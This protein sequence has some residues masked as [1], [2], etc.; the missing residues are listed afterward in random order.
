MSIAVLQLGDRDAVE[1][2]KGYVA[3]APRVEAY[4]V[5]GRVGWGDQ[6]VLFRVLPKLT[7]YTATVVGKNLLNTSDSP[8]QGRQRLILEICDCAVGSAGVF[9]LSLLGSFRS[10]GSMSTKELSTLKS[11]LAFQP[12][13]ADPSRSSEWLFPYRVATGVE[14]SLAENK[15]SFNFISK[16]AK[17]HPFGESRGSVRLI[18]IERGEPIAAAVVK[19]S[20]E[21]SLH[22]QGELRAFG[23]DYRA[24]KLTSLYIARLYS[25]KRGHI[26][27]RHFEWLLRAIIYMAPNVYAEPISYISGV[28]YDFIPAA[29]MTGF[30][31]DLPRQ[32]FGSIFYWK[33]VFANLTARTQSLPDLKHTY[34]LLRAQ[35]QGASWLTSA[36]PARLEI[37]IERGAWAVSDAN[38]NRGRW[39]SVRPGDVL[40]FCSAQR[41]VLGA[42]RIE[43][44][45]RM[46]IPGY[47]RYPLGFK[48][49]S[50]T[51]LPRTFDL[52]GIFSAE[53]LDRVR[54]GGL[55]ELPAEGHY[56]LM[57]ELE[58]ARAGG[59]MWVRPN[60][61]LL[62]RTEFST[63]PRRAFIVQAWELR[64]TIYPLIRKVCE[65]AGWTVSH[66]S[67]REGQAVF[68]DIW[69]L[70]NES[71]A[72]VVD[73]T[74]RRPNVY[75]EYGMALVLGK[76]IIALTQDESDLPS[77]TPNLKIKKYR[78]DANAFM[79]LSDK[80]PR[81][82]VDTVD[83][84]QR[85]HSEYD[86]KR[87]F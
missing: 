70:L 18:L 48:L 20:H 61:Y 34:R 11:S 85:V 58:I 9:D 77:D 33:P 15:A 64:E 16:I 41:T 26:K 5:W 3:L 67:D 51:K 47:E 87:G 6:L 44:T 30:N 31:V 10:A 14:I 66:S 76:P 69:A 29:A 79:D 65:E 28:S 24:L 32:R 38:A 36:D 72:V 12:L 82:L 8:L 39:R 60:P 53:W 37:A 80:L 7:V 4:E 57:E 74:R 78:G 23:R 35:R 45:E 13:T 50:V 73:F 56:A 63:T 59:R 71:E 68:D 81:A 17:L 86:R 55:V 46:R 19:L 75:L 21:E 25:D 49:S 84:I 43:R 62:R 40:F 83:D 54:F 42:A 22:H 1:G 2:G 27:Q 52:H